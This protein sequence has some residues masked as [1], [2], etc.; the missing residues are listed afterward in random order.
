VLAEKTR[1]GKEKGSIGETD[2]AIFSLAMG[3]RAE[4][5]GRFRQTQKISESL[6]KSTGTMER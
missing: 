5:S 2:R 1:R 6:R 3:A 4:P